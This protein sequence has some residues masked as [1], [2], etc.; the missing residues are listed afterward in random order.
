MRLRR[1]TIVQVFTPVLEDEENID[2][3][4]KAYKDTKMK[5]I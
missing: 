5:N 2:E 1:I 3:K 4:I